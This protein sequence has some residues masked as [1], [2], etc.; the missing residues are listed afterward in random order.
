MS[1]VYVFGKPVGSSTLHNNNR[2]VRGEELPPHP[3]P[4]A[5]SLAPTNAASG[6]HVLKM[7]Q[8]L[9][10]RPI[11]S[12]E[13]PPFKFQM[14]TAYCVQTSGSFIPTAR[15]IWNIELSVR[16]GS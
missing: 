8:R 5:P 11:A 1:K 12:Q 9:G 13:E 7:P 16:C 3:L 2:R 15:M 4:V 14:W 10:G 6:R